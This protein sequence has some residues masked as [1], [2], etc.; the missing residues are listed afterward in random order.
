MVGATHW[1][2]VQGPWWLL[3]CCQHCCATV[4]GQRLGDLASARR[5]EIPL[6]P[7]R[8]NAATPKGQQGAGIPQALGAAEPLRSVRPMAVPRTCWARERAS[9]LGVAPFPVAPFPPRC[10]GPLSRR[11]LCCGH[12]A[13]APAPRWPR[14]SPGRSRSPHWTPPRH[15]RRRRAS[16]SFPVAIVVA[17]GE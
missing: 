12:G 13:V 1:G 14:P 9:S 7:L 3:G 2:T 4:P 8:E 15:F 17:G 16:A 10:A 6:L 11:H 5:M